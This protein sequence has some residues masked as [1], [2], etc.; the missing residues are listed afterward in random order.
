LS[1]PSGA[2]DKQKELRGV[3]EVVMRNHVSAV[4]EWR[5]Y[6]CVS[7]LLILLSAG[8]AAADVVIDWNARIGTAAIAACISPADDPLHESRLYAMAHVAIHDALNAIDR[9]SRPYAYDAQV[10]PT[11]S[12]DAAVAA[13][14]RHVLGAVIGQLPFPPACIEAGIAS[15]EADYAA[16]LAAISDGSSKTLGIELGQASA[17]AIVALRSGD[18]A[19]TPLL[20]FDYPQGVNPGE[21]RFTPGFDFAFAPGW[22]RVTPFVLNRPSQFRPSPP[23]NVQGHQYVADYNEIK[24]LGGDNIT[25]S[26]ARTPE[27]T[28]IGLFWIESSPLAWNRLARG[29]AAA[30]GLNP[31]ENARLFGLLNLAMADGYI[32][33]WEA[34]YHYSYWR[35]VTA[36][37]TGDS[38]GNPNTEGDATWTPLQLTYPLPDYDSAHSVEGG[39]A[40]EVLKEFFGTD[41]ISFSACSLTSPAGSRCTDPSPVLRSFASFTEAAEENGLSRIL[42]GIHFRHAVEEGIRHGQR[43]ADRAVNLFLRPVR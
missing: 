18:G 28:E 1:Q 27:Q 19:D 34:K 25:T 23:Y 43:I 15:A 35:P 14:A 11:T 7:P 4:C 41:A 40:A 32:S 2:R 31:W 10:D 29:V 24:A 13:A 21:Y 30:E 22:G 16:A 17:A 42:I 33:S 8:T 20:D 36:I 26:S 12:A 37:Q 38:D 6:F 3:L 39:A 5:L 9:R